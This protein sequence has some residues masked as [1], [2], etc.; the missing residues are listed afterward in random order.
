MIL[1]ADTGASTSSKHPM[2]RFFGGLSVEEKKPLR[3]QPTPASRLEAG[4][5]LALP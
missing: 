4:Q 1:G 5:N 3:F 2:M